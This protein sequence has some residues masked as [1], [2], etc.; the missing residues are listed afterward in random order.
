[1]IIHFS[2]HH[3]LDGAT[4]QVFEGILDILGRLDV[5]LLQEHL[6]DVAFSF[7]H[8]YFVYRFLF[9]C[10]NNRPPMIWILS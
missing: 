6:D 8:L 7:S 1:M 5:I 4:Q 9:S 2:L 3:F 10:H